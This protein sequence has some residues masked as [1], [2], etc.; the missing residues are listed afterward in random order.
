MAT[1]VANQG[2]ADF[3]NGMPG[4]ISFLLRRREQ[5]SVKNQK[6]K[7]IVQIIFNIQVLLLILQESMNA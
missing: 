4:I 1:T 2:L 3:S 5:E 6:V 7:N